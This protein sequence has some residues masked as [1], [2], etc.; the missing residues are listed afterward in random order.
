YIQLTVEDFI[1]SGPS[2]CFCERMFRREC[3]RNRH[4]RAAHRGLPY[5]C[6]SCFERFSLAVELRVHKDK[7]GITKA[8]EIQGYHN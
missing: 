6:P 8:L 3:D 7:H 1:Q 4:T 5:E 2:C